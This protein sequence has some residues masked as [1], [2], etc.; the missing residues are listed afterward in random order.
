[1][2]V[3]CVPGVT[4]IHYPGD[5]YELVRFCF[6]LCF[7]GKGPFIFLKMRSWLVSC[8]IYL[9]FSSLMWHAVNRIIDY[10]GW[11]GR[12]EAVGSSPLPE[13]GQF[14]AGCSGPSPGMES[15]QPPWG[16]HPS[17][18]PPSWQSI[19]PDVWMGDPTF[20]LVSTGFRPAAVHRWEEPG[21][22]PSVSSHEAVDGISKVSLSLLTVLEPVL[23]DGS[24]FQASGH[25]SYKLFQLSLVK[26]AFWGLADVL[27]GFRKS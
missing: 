13:Q 11:R 27:R 15:A 8:F 9:H 20:W 16:T 25:W 1:M 12:L 19:F 23:W 2:C 17:A 24:E 22:V 5:F 26:T 21:S 7:S 6:L 18:S 4:T 3:I 14:C 10:L